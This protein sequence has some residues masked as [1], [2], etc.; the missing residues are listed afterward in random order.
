MNQLFSQRKFNNQLT[1]SISNELEFPWGITFDKKNQQ[2]VISDDYNHCLQFFSRNELKHQGCYGSLGNN[3]KNFFLPAGLCIQPQTQNLLVCDD[4]NNRVQV[5]PPENLN[6]KKISSDDFT[7]I[8]K[9]FNDNKTPMEQSLN[10]PHGISC[11]V[12]GSM[13]V[14]DTGNSQVVLFDPS[15]RYLSLIPEEKTTHASWIVNDVCFLS[16]P[17]SVSSILVVIDKFNQQLIVN[18]IFSNHCDFQSLSKIPICPH[19]Q[20]VCVDFNGYLYLS[21]GSPKKTTDE[22]LREISHVVEI[23]EPRMNYSLLQ[24]LHG[25][26]NDV[27]P[28]DE[29]HFFMPVGLCVD[30]HNILMVVDQGNARIQFFN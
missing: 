29:G 5:I 13:A 30:D 20:C 23:R 25:K 24:I 6:S 28:D 12:D 9:N 21:S 26:T 18:G 14:A 7:Y 3:K 16:P 4:R 8:I 10:R 1:N 2:I 11:D 27:K 17:S 19:P 15:G 22:N